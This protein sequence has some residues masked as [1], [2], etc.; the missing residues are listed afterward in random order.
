MLEHFYHQSIRKVVVS[1]GSLFN[2]IYITRQDDSGKELE[3]IKV[4]ISYGPQQKFMRR[5][6]RIGTDFDNTKVKIKSQSEG[7]V[8]RRGSKKRYFDSDQ[9]G[10]CL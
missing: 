8:L 10:R 6:A 5:L 7:G 1:F 3:R 9:R 2:N 4:P